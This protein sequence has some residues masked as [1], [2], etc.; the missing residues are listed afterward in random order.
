MLPQLR[1]NIPV[2]GMLYFVKNFISN[3][4]SIVLAGYHAGDVGMLSRKFLAL[5]TAEHHRLV[6]PPLR[7]S[8]LTK[9]WHNISFLSHKIKPI[10]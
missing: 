5:I 2:A 9:Q 4:F 8:G 10:F 3:L 6:S 7:R 1:A